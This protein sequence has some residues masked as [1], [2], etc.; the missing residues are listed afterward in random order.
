MKHAWNEKERTPQEPTHSA[1]RQPEAPV[2]L[3]PSYEDR[4]SKEE[5][6]WTHEDVYLEEQLNQAKVKGAATEALDILASR[7]GRSFAKDLLTASPASPEARSSALEAE[8]ARSH[9]IIPE[10]EEKDWE[11]VTYNH[12]EDEEQELQRRYY[13][14]HGMASPNSNLVSLD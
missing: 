6:N 2:T 4:W 9:L 7:T 3:A 8:K 14:R 1:Y 12:P 5:A 13:D 10:E 11:G